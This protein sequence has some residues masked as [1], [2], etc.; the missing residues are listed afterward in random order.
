MKLAMVGHV[1]IQAL[2]PSGEVPL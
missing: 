1:L 2:M